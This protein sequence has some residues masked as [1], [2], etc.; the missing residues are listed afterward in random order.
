MTSQTD[1]I[2]AIEVVRI[3]RGL[4]HR[5]LSTLLG[6]HESSWHKFRTGERPLNL[7]FLTLLMQKLPEVT[8]QVTI[9]IMSQGNIPADQE[10]EEKDGGNKVGGTSE[11]QE[12]A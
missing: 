8:T 4:D 9:Y 2:N 1:L 7:N 6:I 5:D 3:R 10:V 12:R 11:A